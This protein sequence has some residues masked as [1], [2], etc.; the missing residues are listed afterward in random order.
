MAKRKYQFKP[1]RNQTGILNKLYIPHNRRLQLLKWVLYSVLFLAALVLQDSVLSRFRIFGGMI[2]L[3][4]VVMILVAMIQGADSGSVFVLVTSMV[5]VFAGT[6]PGNYAFFLLTLYT[7]ILSVFREEY[8][9]RSMGTNWACSA[10]ALV[11]YEMTV[12][13][14]GVVSG[15]TYWQRVGVFGLTCLFSILTMPVL[16]PL[17][18]RIGKIGGETWKE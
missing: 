9:H 6:G 16:Y 4:P 7:S 8:L 11:L 15:V 14:L 17:V 2:D 13:V 18:E 3:A 1:D 5:Y 12:F 10:V